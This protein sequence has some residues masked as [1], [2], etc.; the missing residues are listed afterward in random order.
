MND[1]EKSPGPIAYIVS[2]RAGLE[3][4]IYREVDVLYKEGLKITL[5]ATK[6]VAG[7][8]YSPKPEWPYHAVS[9]PV[10]LLELPLI[11]LKMLIRPGL[12]IEAIKDKG[13]V[14]LLLATKFSSII[15]KEG[16]KQIHCHFGDHKFFIGYYCKR[17]TGLP[18]SVTIHAHEFYTNPNEHLFR[19]SLDNCD[20]IY[21]IANK[22]VELLKSKYNQPEEKIQLNRLFVDT[23][24]NK[25]Q[26]EIT[27]LAVGRFT[28]RKG[29]VYLMKALKLIDDFKVRAIFVGFGELDLKSIA[30][31]EGVQD[32]VTVYGKMDQDQLRYFYQT[33]DILCVPS[34]TT[35]EEGAEGIPVVLMEGMAC[36]MPVISTPCGAIEELVDNFL[37]P[38]RSTLELA[39]KIRL[40]ATDEL[41]RK[42]L[43]EANRK[44]IAEEYSKHNVIKFGESLSNMQDTND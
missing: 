43:G 27:I 4:F 8:V 24:E 18:L 42:Q 3:A 2:M 44:K 1:N 22:W 29:F 41:L 33:C 15:K 25:P 37:V 9:L 16:I 28:E 12:L 35:E 17:L 31:M 21:P 19:K 39:D 7:D 30:E 11:T 40:L 32:K 5:F 10:F 13:L 26:D 20:K 38:E 14:D 36:G 6:Y 23:Q 34:I